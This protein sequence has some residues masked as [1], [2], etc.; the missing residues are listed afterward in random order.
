MLPYTEK[1]END[2]ILVVDDED[3]VLKLVCTVLEKAGCNVLP[4]RDGD[5]TWAL[6]RT[7]NGP[8][9]LAAPDVIIPGMS[10][11]KLRE[12]LHESRCPTW[13]PC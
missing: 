3:V 6:C 12:Y 1:I 13:S 10:G 5:E 7:Y 8:I 11:P 2:T 4:A 9:H